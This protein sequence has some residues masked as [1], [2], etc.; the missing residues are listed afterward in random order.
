MS[1]AVGVIIL[2][3]KELYRMAAVKVSQIYSNTPY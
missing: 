1:L 3:L 2:A